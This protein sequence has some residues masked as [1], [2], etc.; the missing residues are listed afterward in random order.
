MSGRHGGQLG[1]GV[2]VDELE[3]AAGC[4]RLVVNKY[5]DGWVNGW[6]W[7]ALR[8]TAGSDS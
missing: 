2:L 6:E 5:A 4:G 1:V 3:W 8:R 7:T